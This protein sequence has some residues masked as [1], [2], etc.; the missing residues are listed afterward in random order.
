MSV[1]LRVVRTCV[2][3]SSQTL[4]TIQGRQ[5]T[6]VM[7]IDLSNP[8]VAVR[9]VEAGDEVTDPADETFGSIGSRTGGSPASTAATSTST[10]AA[11]PPA[12]RS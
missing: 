3:E 1:G 6:Q 10:R 8:N 12:A 4:D 5:H 9:A 2:T 11:S 7:N